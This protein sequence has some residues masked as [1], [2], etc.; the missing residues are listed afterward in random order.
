L[1]KKRTALIS[2]LIIVSVAIVTVAVTYLL[3][4]LFQPRSDL[5]PEHEEAER[6][7][8]ATN[9]S[10]SNQ[11]A[12]SPTT[13]PT[14]IDIVSTTSAFPFVQRWSAQYENQH[15]ASSDSV[16]V[17]YLA[18]SEII[19]AEEGSGR[20][21]LAI[22]GVPNENNNTLYVPVSAQAVAI[23]Y[24][25]PSFPDIAS[26][27][28][29]NSTILSLLLNGSITQ[30]DDEAI[31]DLNPNL[32]L[33][34]ER[35]VVVHSSDDDNNTNSSSSSS[36]MLLNQFLGHTSLSWPK[37]DSLAA[38]GPAELAEMVRKIPYSLGY[39]DFSYAVQTR[40]TYAAIGNA[41]G[42]YVVPSMQSIGRAVDVGLQFHNYSIDRS[43]SSQQQ[44]PPTINSSRI[45]SDSYPIV[46]LYY[47]SLLANDDDNE[48]E[49]RRRIVAML[50]FVKWIISESGGQQ[51]LL[52]V[53][54]P[55]IYPGNEQLA[56]YAKII[57]DAIQK[58][59]SN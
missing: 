49:G 2:L 12:A 25:I 45:V 31:K 38:S 48:Q 32:N 3:T 42:D 13:L 35:I 28:R 17:D 58:S 10:S 15:P 46:G 52:E 36:L 18:D 55:P 6:T 33:P 5:L 29:L 30:W 56:T 11:T 21:D 1:S 22:V 50:D 47:A 44:R 41:D 59:L 19:A 34:D 14:T 23:V 9:D 16:N 8:I 39:V 43:S 37:N 26:G 7:Q 40:M 54:Y 4:P 24:N 53:Q 57:T 20:S 27:L 51:A